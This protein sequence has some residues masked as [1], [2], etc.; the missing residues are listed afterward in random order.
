MSNLPNL[1]WLRS[2]ESAARLGSFT[3][4]AQELGL[5]QAAVS[6]H[7]R[8]LESQLGHS[9]F[10]RST[11][12]LTMTEIGK[13]YLPSVRKAIDELALSTAGLFGAKHTGTITLRAPISTTVLVIAPQLPEFLKANPLINVRLLSAIWAETVLETEVDIDVRLGNGKWPDGH[14]ELL[15]KDT[16]VPVC[17]PSLSQEIKSPDALCSTPL[18]HILGFEDQWGRYF[19]HYGLTPSEDHPRVMADTTLAAAELA[20]SGA[21]VALILERAAIRQRDTGRLAIP[22]E[23]SIPLGQDHYLVERDHKTRTRPEVET[24]KDWLRHI[25]N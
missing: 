20:A 25:L 17:T 13:A 8:N 23:T 6:T 9:L 3:A 10:R 24:V 18:I 22:L 19:A 1:L 11:R 12:K 5:T 2:F 16:I 15:A 14:A 21:G 7:I 4:A